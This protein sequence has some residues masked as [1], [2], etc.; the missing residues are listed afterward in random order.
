MLV[1]VGGA[2]LLVLCLLP[3]RPQL[4]L[5]TVLLIFLLL[6][7][8]ASAV[9]GITS[10]IT[11]S[12]LGFGMANFFFAPP[13]GTFVVANTNELVDL[14]VFLA[15]GVL[16]G[17]I[18]E[19][20]ARTRQRNERSRVQAEWLA[21]LDAQQGDADSLD[22]VL[23]EV[24]RIYSVSQVSLSNAAFTVAT[25]GV[26]DTSDELTVAD[27]GEGLQ[28]QLR[29]P[30]RIGS[31]PGPLNSLA[32]TAGRLWRTQQLA[33][34]AS[35]AEELARIDELR[36]SLLAA[37]GHDLRAPIAAIRATAAT[38]AEPSIELTTSE[39]EELLSDLDDN[40]RRLNAIIA[41]LL[42]LTR[43]QAGA[44]S[45]RLAPTSLLEVMAEV[46]RLGAGRVELDVPEDLPLLHA[47][48]GLLERVLANL[49]DN[50]IKH[51]GSERPVS[52]TATA[53]GRQARIAIVDHGRGVSPD[54][55]AEIFRPFQHFEDRS[56][57][58]V[59][60]GLAIARGFTEAMNGR[61]EPSET[62]GGGLT[63][64][65]TL[66]AIDGPAADR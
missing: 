46:L 27:A 48:A 16:V 5:D 57:T 8:I 10:A 4:G 60:L 58:G 49:V 35:R 33:E 6:T 3:A 34:R 41:N 23:L 29:G 17:L 55:F 38:L 13:Y 21:G 22:S 53:T 44:L 42:D 25:L 9:G 37:V 2:P 47:D 18:V 64:T 43:L 50:A 31:D 45:V 19:G 63:M 51:Q 65:V 26:A 39:Q 32:L 40:A 11:A 36:A 20:S 54:R 12:V 61:L 24:M 62:P 59:G 52:I 1:A 28:L 66:G 56:N 7:V 15:V 30:Q 14:V